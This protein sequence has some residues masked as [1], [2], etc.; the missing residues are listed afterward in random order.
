M[1]LNDA[2]S[3]EH[4]E[5]LGLDL[6]EGAREGR[7][8][9]PD[10][11]PRVRLQGVAQAFDPGLQVGAEEPSLA[12][13]VA[14]G[15]V[16]ATD[17]VTHD[18]E[19]VGDVVLGLAAGLGAG[20]TE[21]GQIAAQLRQRLLVQEA[22]QVVGTEQEHLGLA[23]AL[24]QRVELLGRRRHRGAAQGRHQRLPG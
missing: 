24:E 15:G 20:Q 13:E 8:C 3:F 14:N 22:A 9:G 2:G 19:A 1:L 23:D 16:V 12:L 6:H 10:L 11:G 7:H 5:T 17:Q 4:V 21:F 18:L